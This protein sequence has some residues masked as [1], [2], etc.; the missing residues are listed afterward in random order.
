[1]RIKIKDLCLF[2]MVMALLFLV[3]VENSFAR[4]NIAI[5]H[6]DSLPKTT[7][8]NL[9]ELSNPPEFEFEDFIGREWSNEY[10]EYDMG[11]N[12]LGVIK[13]KRLVDEDGNET[14]YQ[15]NFEEGTL[16]FLVNVPEFG[17]VTYKFADDEKPLNT[18]DLCIVQS[19]DFIEITNSKGGI[20]LARQ[21]VGNEAPLR[22][23]R[24][25]SGNWA[26]Q[27]RFDEVPDIADY[28]VT[29]VERGP[30]RAR[31]VCEVL[32]TNGDTWRQTFDV[33][34]FESAVKINEVFDCTKRRV[35]N[36]DFTADF[37]VAYAC[38]RAASVNPVDGVKYNYGQYILQK[39]AGMT[40]S[41]FTLEPWLRWGGS[42][43]VNTSFSLVDKQW[44]DSVFLAASEPALWVNPDIPKAQRANIRID[45]TRT[46]TGAVVLPFELKCGKREYLIGSFSGKVDRENFEAGMNVPTQAQKAQIKH[47]D[48]PLNRIKDWELSWTAG[49]LS[50]SGFLS[51]KDAEYLMKDFEVNEKELL[52]LRKRTLSNHN[53]GEFVPYYMD[54][55]DSELEKIMFESAKF[56]VQNTVDRLVDLDKDIITVGMAPHHFRGFITTCNMIALI[57][58]SKLL[59]ETDLRRLRAQLAFLGYVFNRDAY[60]SPVRGFSVFPNMTACVYGVRA[61]IAGVVPE[62]CEQRTWMRDAVDN[63][64]TMFF[65]SWSDEDGNWIGSNM[66]SLMYTRLS[67][68]IVLGALY[69]SFITGAASAE[70]TILHPTVKQ[71]GRWYAESNTPPD[72]RIKGWR[73]PPPVGHVYKFEVCPSLYAL[74]AVMWRD[75]DPE[76]AAEMKWMQLQQGNSV[77]NSVGGFLPSFA[78][79]RELFMAN[80]IEPKAPDYDSSHWK[81][82]SVI[83]RNHYGHELEN[84]LYMIAGEGHTHYDKDSGSITLWGKGEIIADD[85]GY[86]G[87]APGEDHNMLESLVAPADRLMHISSMKKNEIVDFVRGVKECWTRRIMFVKHDDPLGPN[88]Y[89][90][91]DAL[92]VTA[93]AAWR[94]WLTAQD[95]VFNQVETNHAVVRGLQRIDSDICFAAIPKNS[96]I[97]TEV[98]TCSPHGLFVD[99]EGRVRQQRYDDT[100]TGIIVKSPRFERLLVLVFPRLKSEES[101]KVIQIADGGGFKVTT[102]FGVDYVFLSD[103]PIIYQEGDLAFEG[104]AGFVRIADGVVEL[105]LMEPG[106]VSYG[107]KSLQKSD[108]EATA[109]SSN[110]ISDGELNKGEFTIFPEQSPGSVFDV[111]MLSRDSELSRLGLT[112][113]YCQKVILNKQEAGK[114]RYLLRI[115]QDRVYVDPEQTYRV[116]ARVHIPGTN[117]VF[118]SSYAHDAENRQI[119]IEGRTW[120]WSLGMQG[121]TEGFTEFE[122]TIG[123]KG[124]KNVFPSSAV[125]LPGIGCRIYDDGDGTFFIDDLIIRKVKD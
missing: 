87:Y 35:Y 100:Q 50:S 79:F 11:T 122:T 67:F 83:L 71:M 91:Q 85:F 30:V 60:C 109:E 106:V 123:P 98:K 124:A 101:P 25:A 117:R 23:W 65:D 26:G 99:E 61:A 62:H 22:A 119:K 53:L 43:T 2:W 77:V 4:S 112:D 32:F 89:V 108:N 110:L 94:L 31:V 76:F 45:L 1:M 68:D 52:S 84:M 19:E 55:G 12:R 70:E 3:N 47:S 20:R 17:S 37:Q 78:G 10:V 121:P 90:I 64:K 95:V 66:E 14:L 69:R 18:T 5:D 88:Y 41:V 96:T 74:L 58:D 33:Q 75:Q 114:Q 29:I 63:L 111:K 92:S 56:Q 113:E 115:N 16:S 40:G 38:F 125:M 27:V 8:R 21:L 97:K 81:G 54:T 86:Y 103:K 7:P 57:N 49:D 39:L 80:D 44:N 24:L 118:I 13:D 59:P 51:E 116:R 9:R 6:V 120:G 104:T 72:A 46:S 82:A 105:E 93:P 34:A 73:H 48:Y 36:I 42:A 102:P 28:R 15:L 107:K